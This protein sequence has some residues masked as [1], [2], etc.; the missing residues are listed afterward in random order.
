MKTKQQVVSEFRREEI[1]NAARSVFARKGFADG[2]VDE[3]ATE[4]RLAKGTI[5]LYFKSKREIYKAVLQHD[6]EVLK[7]DTL[8]R[9][10]AANGL[11]EKIR[12]FILARL[13]NAEANREFFSIMD[14]ESA[15]VSFTRTQ[16]REWLKEPVLR[17]AL[18]IEDAHRRGD[19]RPLPSEKVAWVIADMTRGS[20]QRRILGQS[21]AKLSQDAE[22]LL[23]LI[24]AALS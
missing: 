21:D 19:I 17:L 14:K 6:M 16:Y 12:A 3:I 8:K 10:D 9:I 13:E 20:I 5:Y 7:A 15:S 1:L 23:D 4:A 24:L 18:A 2:I 22:F 11:R